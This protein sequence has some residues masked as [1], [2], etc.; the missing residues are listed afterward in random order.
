M[1]L[2]YLHIDVDVAADKQ[3]IRGPGHAAHGGSLQLQ[4]ESDQ[5]F[6]LHNGKKGLTRRFG[7]GAIETDR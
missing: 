7:E 4:I 6:Q 3:L 5:E 1:N 2:P